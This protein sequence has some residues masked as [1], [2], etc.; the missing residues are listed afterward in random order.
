MNT[1]NKDLMTLVNDLHLQLAKKHDGDYKK[2]YFTAMG[3]I[4]GLLD[5]NYT[6]H[7][8]NSFIRELLKE[9]Q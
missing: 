9:Y 4:G 1:Q 3:I 8:A 5:Q 6:L 7:E 2:M